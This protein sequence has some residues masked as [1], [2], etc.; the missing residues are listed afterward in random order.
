METKTQSG[1]AKSGKSGIQATVQTDLISRNQVCLNNICVDA[2][3]FPT[4]HISMETSLNQPPSRPAKFDS[5]E[6]KVY[7]Q[8]WRT[9]DCLKAVEDELFGRFGLSAQQYN[10]LRLL[11][12]EYPE[13]LKTMELG[14]RLIS[15][16]PDITRMLDRL[17]QRGLVRRTRLTENRRVVQV[18]ITGA[19]LELLREMSGEVLRMHRHQLGHLDSDRQRQLI[20]LLKLA[21]APHEDSSCDWLE[22]S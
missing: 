11:E 8:L 15:R 2:S 20:D 1:L 22:H 16:G 5:A 13:G 9:Y 7:L 6:Q 21:R 3:R 18:V 17:E 19:G 14:A 10:V 12:M 4:N